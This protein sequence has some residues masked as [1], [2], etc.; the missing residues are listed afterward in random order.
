MSVELL[1]SDDKSRADITCTGK[2]TGSDAHAIVDLLFKP[3]HL[4]QLKSV[5]LDYTSIES[6]GLNIHDLEYMAQKSV[7]AS[8]KNPNIA[9]ALITSRLLAIR[10]THMWEAFAHKAHMKFRIFA[11][12]E[13]AEEWLEQTLK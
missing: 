8:E 10:L 1:Y 7:A 11:T 6:F 2:L 9:I 4:L 13:P 5:M 3:D 12:K